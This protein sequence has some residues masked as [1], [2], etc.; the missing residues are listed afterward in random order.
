MLKNEY[1]PKV[2]PHPGETLAEKLDEMG[3]GPKEFAIRSGKPEKTITAILKGDSAITPD[4]AVQFEYATKIPAHFWMNRQL[5][6]DE[7]LAR[8]KYQKVLGESAEWVRH[9]PFAD[10]VKKG[11]LKP[12]NTDTEKIAELLSFF[13][14]AHYMAWND[15]YLNQELK[16]VFRISL[17]HAHEPHAVSA[18]IRRGELQAEPL[19]A[20]MYSEK[21]FREILPDIKQIMADHPTDFFQ[22]LHEICLSAG[23]KVVHTPC[24]PKAP[25]NGTTRW[26]NDAPL[27]QLSGRYKR[28]DVFWFTFFHEAGHILLH[29]KKEVFV[30]SSEYQKI[31]EIQENEA[32]VFAVKWTLSEEEESEIAKHLPLTT[33]N[34][35]AYAQTYKTHPAMIIGRFQHKG[36]INHSWGRE[37][38][39]PVKLD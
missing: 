36:Y 1:I 4:M 21:R 6:Y 32:D 15:Y 8:I 3:M 9:F 16:V 34:I 5:G 28:N 22:R 37:F 10:M 31:N 18:F 19:K 24:L 30:E 35:F 13:G 11:W 7:Y 20:A 27:I 25:I 26:I 12:A 38:I 17:A 29:G 23:V 39:I 33:Q 14:F 2:V